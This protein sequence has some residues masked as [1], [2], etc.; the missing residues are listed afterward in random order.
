MLQSDQVSSRT[1]D[2]VTLLVAARVSL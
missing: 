2:D 1:P